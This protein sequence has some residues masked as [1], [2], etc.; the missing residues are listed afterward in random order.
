MALPSEDRVTRLDPVFGAMGIEAG[1][2]IWSDSKLNPREK[3]TLL[4]AADVR[5]PELGLPFELH[6]SMALKGADMSV[7][8]LREVLRQIAPYAGLNITSMAFERM[9]EVAQKA[10]YDTDSSAR[11]RPGPIGEVPYSEPELARLRSANARL[12]NSL[13]RISAE[14]WHRENLS[15][16]ERALAMLAID[17]VGGTLGSP[18]DRHVAIAR[19]VGLAKEELSEMIEILSEFSF[20]RAWQAAEALQRI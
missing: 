18:F 20:P 17:I 3:A 15:H 14:L 7:E 9:I 6:I 16:R 2:A 13:S 1:R 11:R 12:A 19:R 5:V 4:I 10:G 8:H